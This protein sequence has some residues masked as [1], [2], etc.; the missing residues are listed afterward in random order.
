MPTFALEYA[1]EHLA[2]LF[3]QARLGAEVII[4]R[5]DGQLCELT[6][7]AEARNEQPSSN[8]VEIPTEPDAAP[9]DLIPA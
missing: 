6:P 9:G 8:V 1:Q 7:L 4:I 5:E 2:D 3:H